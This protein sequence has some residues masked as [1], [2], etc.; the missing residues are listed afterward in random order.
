[1]S[2]QWKAALLHWALACSVALFMVGFLP[3]KA[4]LEGRAEEGDV[5]GEW[6]RG[7]HSRANDTPR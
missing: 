1:M 2:P 4:P 6:P 5:P 3:A 7:Y